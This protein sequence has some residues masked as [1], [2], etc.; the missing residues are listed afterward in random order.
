MYLYV[1]VCTCMYAKRRSVLLGQQVAD[2]AEQ[3]GLGGNGR[4][5]G[6]LGS[7]ALAHLVHG[8]H[9]AEVNSGGHQQE[10]DDLGQDGA[11]LYSL[12]L[13]SILNCSTESKFGE[14]IS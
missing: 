9:D 7:L 8:Q 2:L 3:L 10:V 4:S 5:C 14:P 6:F 13:G 12:E 1:P 11:G